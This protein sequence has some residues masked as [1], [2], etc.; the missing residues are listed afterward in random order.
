MSKYPELIANFLDF[1]KVNSRSDP[2]STTIPSSDRETK[3]L[4]TLK[5]MLDRM[6]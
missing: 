2:N 4:N 5:E 3:F 1:V 6:G